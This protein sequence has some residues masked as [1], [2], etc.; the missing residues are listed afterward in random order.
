MTLVK[1]IGPLGDLLSSGGTNVLSCS[2]HLCLQNI[3]AYP[4][5]HFL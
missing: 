4:F 5:L 2:R 3:I 1:F